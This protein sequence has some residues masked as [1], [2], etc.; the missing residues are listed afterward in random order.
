VSTNDT[1]E[2]LRVSLN[3]QFLDGPWGRKWQRTL[4]QLMDEAV[5]RLV[6]ARVA[7]LPS[8]CP[9]DGLQYIASERQLER[10]FGE[11]IPDY[12]EVLRTAWTIWA[13]G[14]SA[15]AHISSLGR[16]GFG[17]VTVKRRH[18]FYGVPDDRPYINAFARS[19]WAQ[20]D[21]ICQKPMPWQLRVWG[22]PDTWGKGVWG[23]TAQPQEV[24]QMKRFLR[25]FRAG[26]DT[27]MYAYFNFG[28]GQL[29]GLGTWGVGKWGGTGQSVRILIG[30]EHWKQRGLV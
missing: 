3:K 11:S 25:L 7:K 29:W 24:E 12:R 10:A 16:M 27:P 4:G 18:D 15:Q 30:E 8:F 23:L 6:Q 21:I 1:F 22:P 14:G 9:E 13:A 28:S 19:V 20:F 26:H 5:N 17:S 2:A